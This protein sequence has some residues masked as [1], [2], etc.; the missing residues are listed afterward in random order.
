MK[1]NIK[2]F[3]LLLIL[4][5]SFFVEVHGQVTGSGTDNFLTK[6]DDGFLGIIKDSQIQDN[7]TGV[8][9][10]T[11]PTI[12]VRL[13][14]NG[15]I[16]S[17]SYY[18]GNLP[19]IYGDL[20]GSVFVGDGFSPI[21]TDNTIVGSQAGANNTS[22][23]NTIIG[24]HAG[25]SGNGSIF[26]GNTA[27][28]CSTLY[29]SNRYGGTAVGVYAGFSN[30]TGCG[31]TAIGEQSLSDNTT[32][33]YNVAL[34]RHSGSNL[35]TGNYNTF[36][37]D[38][39]S[40]PITCPACTSISYATAIG[41]GA[42]VM[43]SNEIILGNNS[44]YVGIGYSG[45]STYPPG[46]LS[47]D[48]SAGEVTSGTIAGYFHN[49]DI[50]SEARSS[51]LKRGLYA[52]SNGLFA[53]KDGW[54]F[55][56]IGGDFEAYNSQ[57]YNV[58]VRGL[59]GIVPDADEN[60]N[61]GGW[62]EGNHAKSY[63]IGVYASAYGDAKVNYGI[64][65]SAPKNVCG[66]GGPCYDAAGFFNGDVFTTDSYFTSDLILKTNIQPLQ[67]SM[68]V[69]KALQ[70]KTYNYKT[71]Q[72]PYLN[73]PNGIQD[74][75][76][77]QEVQSVLPELV[78]SFKVPARRDSSG[79]ID[80]T[81]TDQSFLAINYVKLIPYL[82]AAV[83]E[84]QESIDSLKTQLDTILS[85]RGS[86]RIR[87][88]SD[89]EETREK[90]RAIINVE[91]ADIKTIILDQNS[92]NPFSEETFINYFIPKEVIKATIMIYDK[93]GSVLKIVNVNERG[94]GQLHIFAENLSNGIYTYSLIADGKTIDSKRM[95]FQ[96]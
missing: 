58:A 30:T 35:K 34:G 24:S 62:F 89:S 40:V 15:V 50:T 8:G 16:N 75:L 26:Y 93:S 81:G 17:S 54:W 7:G 19:F 85:Q 49:G 4:L 91:L 53:Q 78:S 94:D 71:S 25:Y 31:I 32:G 66:S 60:N 9:I 84:Q 37:G 92:P 13:N 61:Y 64:Y 79:G 51:Y 65:A 67:N 63:N 27:V 46:K 59:T 95:I 23:N 33:N 83:K 29:N 72:F 38:Y 68:Q 12:G 14:V 73:L 52:I 80:T 28:G 47:V 43:N 87:N 6:W 1:R 21:G 44:A 2:M 82:I 69:L 74:G 45:V 22:Y 96:K 57:V 88:N 10:G 48:E 3:Q 41:A 90:E 86:L 5:V 70:P 20:S 56:N 76:I 39:A 11:T 55:A 36:L 18:L 77:A 42:E